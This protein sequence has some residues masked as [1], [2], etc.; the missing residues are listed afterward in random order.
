LSSRVAAAVVLATLIMAVAAVAVQAA[1]ELA[2]VLALPQAP[3]TRLRSAAVVLAVRGLEQKAFRGLI[4]YLAPSLPRAAAAQ[5]VQTAQGRQLAALERA[6]QVLLDYKLER[7]VTPQA[8]RRLKAITV[9]MQLM[10]VAVAVA[11]LLLG[12]PLNLHLPA[13][14]VVQVQHRLFLAVP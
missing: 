13:A 12:R 10:A 14:M 6:A 7:L 9:V 8:P 4:Q 1:L 11:L 5:Q 2:Q 3:I